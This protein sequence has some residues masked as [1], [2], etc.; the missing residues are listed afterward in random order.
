L[1]WEGRTISELEDIEARMEAR[2]HEAWASVR[3]LSDSINALKRSR[4]ALQIEND[5]A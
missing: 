2:L 3:E 4:Y 5:D 1:Y